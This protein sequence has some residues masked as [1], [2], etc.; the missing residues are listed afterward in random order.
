ML[1]PF[2]FLFMYIKPYLSLTTPSIRRFVKLSNYIPST[3]QLLS[4]YISVI[5]TEYPLYYLY[6][7]THP[8]Y[9]NYSNDHNVKIIVQGI[10]MSRS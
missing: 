2:Q 3:F 6:Q 4:M 1:K 8:I 10:I 9:V 5:N 7:Y